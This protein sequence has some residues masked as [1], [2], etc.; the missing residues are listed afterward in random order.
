MLEKER[1]GLLGNVPPACTTPRLRT[2]PFPHTGA[3]DGTEMATKHGVVVIAANYRLDVFG[4]LGL[5][6]LQDEDPTS[7]YGNYG[8]TP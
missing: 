8:T 6:E 1:A 3:Y 4:W 7:A 2:V 5:Q